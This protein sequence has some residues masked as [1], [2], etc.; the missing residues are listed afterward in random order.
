MVNDK[1]IRTIREEGYLLRTIRVRDTKDASA[2]R[3]LIQRDFD[4]KG[5]WESGVI[6]E[7]ILGAAELINNL[8]EHGGGGEVQYVVSG[9]HFDIM[10]IQERPFNGAYTRITSAALPDLESPRG[11]GLFLLRQIFDYFYTV[12]DN[13]IIGAYKAANPSHTLSQ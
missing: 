5:E 6:D 8:A 7:L 3:K 10:T 11:R 13:R 2:V 9:S 1:L 4:F 12:G